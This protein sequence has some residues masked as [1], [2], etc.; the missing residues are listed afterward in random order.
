MASCFSITF[1]RASIRDLLL[2]K[3]IWRASSSVSRR[4]T[5]P[6]AG[7]GGCALVGAAN[8]S[9]AIIAHN[10]K[11]QRGKVLDIAAPSDYLSQFAPSPTKGG[12]YSPQFP[13]FIVTL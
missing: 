2:D 12:V 7:T 5:G 3:A 9:A 6:E 13:F 8:R 1:R 4:T 10:I 11:T